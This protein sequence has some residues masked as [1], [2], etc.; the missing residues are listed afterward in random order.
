MLLGACMQ[1]AQQVKVSSIHITFMQK[2]QWN[3]AGEA[4]FLQRMDQ[5]FHWHNGNYATF[6][7]F[8]ADLARSARNSSNVA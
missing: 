4:G 5:Q 1:I 6:D 3:S 2:D 7:E 8:L